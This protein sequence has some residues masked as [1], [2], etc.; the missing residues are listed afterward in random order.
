MIEAGIIIYFL[1]F[2]ETGESHV[3][4]SYD[5]ERSLMAFPPVVASCIT[6]VHYH[7]LEIDIDKIHRL[8]SAFTIICVRVCVCTFKCVDSWNHQH[9]Q[10]TERFITRIPYPSSL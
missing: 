6:M 9:N 5:T 8:H 3:V 7:N 1:N 10:D 2:E 4:V